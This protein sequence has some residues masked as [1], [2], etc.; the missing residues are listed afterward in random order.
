MASRIIFI[1]LFRY[2]FRWWSIWQILV[3]MG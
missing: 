3:W 2:F 1:G